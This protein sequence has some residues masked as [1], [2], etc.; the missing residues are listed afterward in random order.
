[1]PLPPPRPLAYHPG[2]EAA[3]YL[4]LDPLVERLLATHVS[5]GQS[6][7]LAHRVS[8][9]LVRVESRCG[10]VA[11]RSEHRCCRPFRL[12]VPYEPDH[13]SVSTSRSSNRAC[14]LPALGS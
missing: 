1:G 14:D 9:T 3:Q 12:A 7:K 4:R 11:G 13:G 2:L 6:P 10:A 5:V 8:Q